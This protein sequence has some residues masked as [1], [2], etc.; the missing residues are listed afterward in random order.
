MFLHQI[1]RNGRNGHRKT[2]YKEI[3]ADNPAAVAAAEVAAL[4]KGKIPDKHV[5]STEPT[6]T[7][8]KT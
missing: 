3:L 4:K 6:T 2:R 1:G 5:V 8:R 7:K